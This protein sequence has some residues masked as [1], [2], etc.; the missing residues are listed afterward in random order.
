MWQAR[1]ELAFLSKSSPRSKNTIHLKRRTL[2]SSVSSPNGNKEAKV[3]AVDLAW[4]SR[5]I[6]KF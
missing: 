5:G 4:D 2:A 1:R 3:F 6:G